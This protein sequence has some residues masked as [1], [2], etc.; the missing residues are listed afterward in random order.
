MMSWALWVKCVNNLLQSKLLNWGYRWGFC[1]SPFLFLLF[2][3]APCPYIPFPLSLTCFDQRKEIFRS[4]KVI[5]FEMRV[6][7]NVTSLADLVISSILSRLENTFQCPLLNTAVLCIFSFWD[8]TRQDFGVLI[9]SSGYK[10]IGWLLQVS[11]TDLV[12]VEMMPSPG[13]WIFLLCKTRD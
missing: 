9:H 6:L 3:V 5:T 4:C 2:I 13:S 1:E 8:W 7:F 12:T 10:N 11:L